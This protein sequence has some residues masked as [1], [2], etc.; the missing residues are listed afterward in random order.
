MASPGERAGIF[1]QHLVDFMDGDGLVAGEIN[2]RGPRAFTNEDFVGYE[3]WDYAKDD[4]AGFLR[5][6]D[7][8]MMTG[9]FI[10]VELLRHLAAGGEP[11]LALA[12]RAA[13]AIL[14]VS[15]AG[16]L[17]EPGYLPKP[18]GGLARAGESRA[19]SV[20]QYEHALFATWGL[21][22]HTDDRQLA[23]RI[24][25]AIVKWADYFRRHDFS[26]DYFGRTR[27]TPETS[28]HTLGLALPLC[29]IAHR[30]T[31]DAVY[32]EDLEAQLGHIVRGSLVEGVNPGGG[33]HPNTVNLTVMGL[34]YC[35]RHSV[36]KHECGRAV[37]VWT[38]KTLQRLSSD[39]LAYCYEEGSDTH[40][41]EPRF[42]AME[43][44]L[45]YR[46]LRWRSNV[47]G[48]DSCKI[49]HTLVLAHHVHPQFGWREKALAILD[50]FRAVS[51]FRRY[52][53]YNGQQMPEEYAYMRDYLCNQHIGAWLQ[54]YY[55]A[56]FPRLLAAT[57][58]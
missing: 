1:R 56:H 36:Y 21:R 49:A 11:G 2:V 33:G 30:I 52:H 48:A 41:A 35:W 45:G 25:E 14:A 54:A 19:I 3:T 13:R 39:N 55:L 18:H 44:D 57:A 29:T 17:H 27:S 38:R 20:D 50:R 22:H 26:Y 31:G 8:L 43:N 6:E 32:L 40:P 5:Y 15:A 37:E 51:E 24:D 58:P 28:V 12:E 34:V 10:H 4:F 47:K 53:D 7:A 46:F 9:R 23:A 42:V 16:D